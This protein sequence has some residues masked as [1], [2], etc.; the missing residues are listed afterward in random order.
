MRTAG[1]LGIEKKFYDT[2]LVGY[3]FLTPTD[4]A[5]GE[6]NPSATIALNTVTQGDGESQRDGRKMVM[7]SIFVSG[8]VYFAPE[9]DQENLDYISNVY[10]AL[11]L[12]TQTNGAALS[13]ENVFVNPGASSFTAASP[14]RNLQYTQRFK[15]LKSKTFAM[16]IPQA[17]YNGGISDFEVGG[18]QTPFSWYVPLSNIAVNF[19][20]TTETIANIVDNSIHL[21]G[22]RSFGKN[23]FLSY[24][25]RLRFVG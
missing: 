25:T 15:I 3:T 16:P 13:S 17:T 6:A 7:T 10:L 5:G 24:N 14:L 11:V 2:S 9:A 21:V 4:A 19:S 8:I 12:D 18:T 1:F 23:S 22:Y 20:G